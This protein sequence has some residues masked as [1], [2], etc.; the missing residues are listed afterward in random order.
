MR[1]TTAS[2]SFELVRQTATEFAISLTA[3]QR[4]S[5][6]LAFH[7]YRTLLSE[8][9]R[10]AMPTSNMSAR[11]RRVSLAV[12]LAVL[13]GSAQAALHAQQPLDAA[14]IFPLVVD[15]KTTTVI[16]RP[17]G[18]LQDNRRR[19]ERMAVED[20]LHYVEKSTGATLTVTENV[21]A[22]GAERPVVLLA[23]AG[24]PSHPGTPQTPR[25]LRRH[26]FFFEVTPERMTIL[27]ADPRGL[28]NGVHWFLRNRL[29]V[30]WYMPTEWGE[31]VPRR[32]SV[33]LKPEQIFVDAE[34]EWL[35]FTGNERVLPD[36]VAWGVRHGD[37]LW[38]EDFR[39]HWHFQ[40]NWTNLLPLT[41]ENVAEH[42]DWW[43]REKGQPPAYHDELNVCVS[44]PEVIE[45]FVAAARRYFDADPDRVMLSLESNDSPTYCQCH[46]CEDLLASLG[47]G[48]T[49]CDMYINFCNRVIAEVRTT[50]PD[51]LYGFY[52]YVAYGDHTNPPTN[53][54]P[55]PSLR[56]LLTRYGHKVCNRHAL[57]DPRCRVNP[58]WRATFEGWSKALGN[59]GV[60]D[61]WAG[62]QWFGPE[63]HTR[64]AQDLPLFKSLGVEYV[65]SEGGYS[66]GTMGPFYYQTARLLQ[67]TSL[68]GAELIDEFCRG[69]YGA[70]H[71]PMRRYWQ[72]WIDA[73][74]AGP[75]IETKVDNTVLPAHISWHIYRYHY[76]QVYTPEL[77][78]AASKD[79][80]EALTLVDTAPQRYRIRVQMAQ[81][82]L[83]Y[84][85]LIL[86]MYRH[87]A[88][89][90][91]LQACE[92][93]ER[94][95]AVMKQSRSLP[96]ADTFERRSINAATRV[97]I[98]INHIK[99]V[100]RQRQV[101]QDR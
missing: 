16:L 88:A 13:I 55:D 92:P 68:D 21:E 25:P 23:V 89:G 6:E 84:T 8:L 42:P 65:C 98:E 50:H 20:L 67:D 93:A 85:D 61:Y 19:L 79:I 45:Q 31:E 47:G 100:Y 26:A 38:D 18:N 5:L 15:Q 49:Q 81:F 1:I 2:V 97:A 22:I 35:R 78:A 40:K 71:V 59:C 24:S 12:G 51:K 53:V 77:I 74:D 87:I 70:G 4:S 75:A 54:K 46:R 83:R 37:N 41:R 52:A 48:A 17:A 43:A 91:Y 95:V 60:Y 82:G 58:T 90:D 33:K 30:R 96:G 62:Y 66:W 36:E 39:D 32:T 69:M 63:P 29:G 86:A 80:D 57:E 27:G 94:A 64:L 76:D 72:R 99:R 7:L 73:F 34:F 9:R 28:A 44:N 10:R 11:H 56:V 14:A 3:T 101:P